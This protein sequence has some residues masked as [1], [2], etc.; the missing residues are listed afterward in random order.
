MI[1]FKLNENWDLDISETGDISTTTSIRQ[2]VIIRLKW[3]LEEWR[4]GTSLGFPYR[5]EVFRKNP[6]ISKIKQL[7]RETVVAVDGVTRVMYVT[8]SVDNR[9]RKALINV[10]FATSEE[11]YKEEVVL[12]V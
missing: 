4:L 6:N 12:Y 11:T 10:T 1:D 9:T 2:A 8:I 7:V 3:F 5:E